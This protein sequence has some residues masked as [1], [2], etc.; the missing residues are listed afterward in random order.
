MCGI[1][2]LRFQHQTRIKRLFTVNVS[3]KVQIPPLVVGKSYMNVI[4]IIYIIYSFKL[5]TRGR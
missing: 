5:N 3:K 1:Y 4:Y 2:S